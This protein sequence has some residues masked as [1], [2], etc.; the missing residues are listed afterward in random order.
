MGGHIQPGRQHGSRAGTY[1]R[2][3]GGYSAF[4]PEPLPPSPPLRM[5]QS[6]VSQLSA[7]DLALGRLDG[8]ALTLPDPDLFVGMYVRQE[9]VLSSQI[10][11]TQ[12]SLA[13]LLQLELWEQGGPPDVRE[14]VNYVNA[15]NNGLERLGELPL[16]LRLVREI[17]R[18]LMAG[19]RG[20]EREAGEFRTAQNWVGAPGSTPGSAI[21]VPPPPSALD[22]KSVV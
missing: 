8:A 17:H 2:Q 6:L 1:V 12:A 9:A 21:F 18:R 4:L 15:M 11:G 20:G 7:A 16:S 5:S 10:E 3:P 22:R 19:V 13:D 14:V